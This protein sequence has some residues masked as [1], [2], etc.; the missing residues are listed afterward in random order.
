MVGSHG[1]RRRVG[2]CVGVGAAGEGRV[3]EGRGGR[4]AS[5]SGSRGIERVSEGVGALQT[6]REVSA[7]VFGSETPRRR[8]KGVRG[9]CPSGSSPK[10]GK[11]SVQL[12]QQ[13]RS[14][15][16]QSWSQH[17]QSPTRQ[18]HPRPSRWNWRSCSSW[19]RASPPRRRPPHRR[20]HTRQRRRPQSRATSCCP[21]SA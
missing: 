12:E 9:C 15:F 17:S 1:E 3:G 18:S 14:H 5:A 16:R 21:F 20:S 8:A 13:R 7:S 19:Q 11:G 6:K 4:D 10:E 2:E